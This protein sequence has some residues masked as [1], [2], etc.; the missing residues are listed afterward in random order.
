MKLI[1]AIIL[2]ISTMNFSPKQLDYILNSNHSFNIAS[3]V[4]SS[5]KTFAQ[6][7]RWIDF[8]YNEVPDNKLLL[9]SG[10]TSESLYDNIIRDMISPEIDTYKDF[11]YHSQPQRLIVKS[12]NIEIACASADNEGSWGRTQGKTVYGWL[13]DEIVRHPK[14]FVEMA[15]SRC[16]G[17]GKIW[18]K[19]WTCNPDR[20]SHFIK[21]RYIDSKS[22]DVKNWSFG[23][24][25]NPVLSKEYIEEV[26]NS[27]S[28]IFYQRFIEGR[29]THAEGIIYDLFNRQT[30]VKENYPKERIVE[31]VLGLDWGYENPMAIYLIGVTGD[32]QYWIIDE[33][34]EKHLLVDESLTTKIL[35]K[36][37]QFNIQTI[38]CDPSRP[39]Y[40][41]QLYELFDYKIQVVAAQN[42]VI[43]GIQ[44]VQKLFIKRK[45]GEHGIY[46]LNA[47]IHLI[48]ELEGYRWKEGKG[49]IVKDEPVKEN[50]HGAD[51]IRYCIFSRRNS[52]KV[53]TA[54]AEAV[55]NVE[56]NM[57]GSTSRKLRG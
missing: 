6:M 12:K 35:N 25:D 17:D 50:D 31:Y 11:V 7:T 32:N 40:I 1:L 13:A 55:K 38:Y 30:Y 24:N 56:I 42:D 20:P 28:G 19:F 3:G 27:Y 21:K 53:I 14:N 23:F 54:E 49:N 5:G 44:E 16:R 36:W 4:V 52:N 18:P 15:V 43:E 57:G 37:E 47:C 22:L 9:M 45:N 51:G 41:R 33:I 48:E 2:I 34:Y 10:K 8:I 39:E 46:I 29:W 26:K